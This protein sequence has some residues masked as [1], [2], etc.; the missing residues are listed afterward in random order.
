MPAKASEAAK[1]SA[2]EKERL[3]EAARKVMARAYAPYSRF[4]VGAALLTEAGNLY[5]GCNVENASYGLTMCAE[6][7]AIGTGVAAEGEGMKIR[8]LAVLN[9]ANAACAPCGACRQVIWEFGRNAVVIYQGASGPVETTAAQLLP[10][11]FS[12]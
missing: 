7:V 6:R 11:G 8:A 4:H 3:L 10:A 5:C 9:S 1:I 12:L 2:Q